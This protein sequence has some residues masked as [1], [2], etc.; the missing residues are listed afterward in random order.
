MDVALFVTT[1]RTTTKAAPDLAVRHDMAAVHRDCSHRQSNGPARNRL[2][3][4]AIPASSQ[5]A[6]G[7]SSELR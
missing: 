7:T 2:S 1:C 3:A 5:P 6:A 4:T